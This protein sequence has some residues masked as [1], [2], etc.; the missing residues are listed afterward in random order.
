MSRLLINGANIEYEEFGTGT[1]VVLC[2]GGRGDMNSI[3]GLAE[4]LS[5]H[6][7]V[8][9]HDRRNCGASDVVIR[10]D[11]SEHE[12]WTEDLWEL[13]NRLDAIPSYI[14]GGSN[15]SA[16]SL[17]MANRYPEAVNG[18]LL[19]NVVGGRVAR[20][21]LGQNYYGQFIEAAQRGG[22]L[23]VIETEFFSERIR[24]N[25]SN[26][27]RL[28]S[29][30]SREFINVMSRWRD[31]FTAENP[32]VGSTEIAIRAIQVRTA[33]IPG[34]DEVHPKEVG[35]NLH[36]ILTNSELYDPV[37]S[38]SERESHSQ[39]DPAVVR[40]FGYDR[41]VSVFG[42]FLRGLDEDQASKD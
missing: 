2:A 3:R 42:P 26:R 22:M 10:G 8:I 31:F 16:V 14:G 34:N 7:R 5:G 11:L 40:E 21:R 15:G 32:V 33:I 12:L 39:Q 1:S 37:W 27:E 23:G 20:E 28:M 24:Q 25:P 41:M 35:E 29:M 30:D 13:L 4:R 9:L 38:T 19:W 18:L 17:L 36:S 6:H